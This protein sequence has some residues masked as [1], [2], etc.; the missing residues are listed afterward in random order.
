M[1]F[2]YFRGSSQY[3]K[4]NAVAAGFDGNPLEHVS[5]GII[6]GMGGSLMY[7]TRF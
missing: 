6:P 5:F 4:Q 3:K 7:S 1:V 2:G